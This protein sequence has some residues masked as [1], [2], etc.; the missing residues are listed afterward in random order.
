MTDK[1]SLVATDYCNRRKTQMTLENIHNQRRKQN[2]DKKTKREAFDQLCA[3]VS[4][5]KIYIEKKGRHLTVGVVY[6]VCI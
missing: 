4:T 2:R 3:E 6:I 1:V 5:K